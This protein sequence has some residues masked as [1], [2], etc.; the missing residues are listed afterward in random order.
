MN[1]SVFLSRSVILF[2]DAEEE[3]FI[4]IDYENLLQNHYFKVLRCC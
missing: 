4:T 3:G 1:L 2:F